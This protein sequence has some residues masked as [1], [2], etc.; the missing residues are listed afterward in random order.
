MSSVLK[1]FFQPEFDRFYKEY[2]KTRED[3]EIKAA[4]AEA[5]NKVAEKDAE[6]ARLRAQL[7]AIGMKDI[8][9]DF[10]SSRN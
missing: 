1:E 2:V 9:A 6:I 5:E 3:A 8:S 7:A 10:Q 4:I